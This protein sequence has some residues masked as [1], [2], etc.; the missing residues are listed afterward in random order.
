MVWTAG[1]TSLWL[2]PAGTGLDADS[3]NVSFVE[4][5]ALLNPAWGRRPY[6]REATG[7][8]VVATDRSLFGKSLRLTA[9][10]TSDVSVEATRAGCGIG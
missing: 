2:T 3:W 4:Y 7:S 9:R 5:F 6:V 10:I 1:V 8:I